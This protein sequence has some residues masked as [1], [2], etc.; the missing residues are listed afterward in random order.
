LEALIKDCPGL[1]D[2][3]NA[4]YGQITQSFDEHIAI[5]LKEIHGI[6]AKIEYEPRGKALKFVT[7]RPASTVF[8]RITNQRILVALF[9]CHCTAQLPIP[10]YVMGQGV[11]GFEFMSPDSFEQVAAFIAKMFDGHRKDL[12]WI[13]W[14]DSEP[15]DWPKWPLSWVEIWE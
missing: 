2:K 13:E 14:P 8:A 10:A 11:R 15:L 6:D 9:E 7:D 4:A 12:N 5:L 1:F 3:H